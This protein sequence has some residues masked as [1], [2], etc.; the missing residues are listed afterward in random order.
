M[1]VADFGAGSGYFTLL[2]GEKV[3]PSGQVVA[4]DILESAL[5]TI[6]SRAAAKGLKN[7]QT[8]RADLE[9]MGG[10][11]LADNSQDF[12]LLANILFQSDKPVEIIREA[13]RVL[14]PTGLV[15]V[16]DWKK[17]SMGLGPP[18]EARLDQETLKQNMKDEGFV[19]LNLLEVG[20]F[21][22]G[23]MFEKQA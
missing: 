8:I 13:K 7:I 5:D 14:K 21:H 9:V 23:L 16:I 10:S 12:I 18:E 1:K 19:F 11:G 20:N 17:G 22:F 6:R 15:A 3:G 4:L 2:L